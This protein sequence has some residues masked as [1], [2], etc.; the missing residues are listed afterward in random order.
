MDLPASA[1]PVEIGVIVRPHGV[2][3]AV[4]VRL[5]NPDTSLV[6]R[7]ARLLLDGRPVRLVEVQPLPD[8]RY[9]IV[10][11]EGVAD[12]DAAEALRNQPL[13]VR[14]ADLPPL[15]PGEYYHV[16]VIGA[17]VET[18]A[19]Q[20]IGTVAGIL[21]TNV[22]VLEVRRPDGSEVLIPVRDPYVLSIDRQHGVIV[23]VEPEYE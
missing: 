7:G 4:K 15:K 2:R 6:R 22:D 5:H 16:E 19:G 1:D 18:P 9:C 23:A 13:S 12:C 14:R 11:L 17:R 21:T 20:V 10:H 8:C 3:G